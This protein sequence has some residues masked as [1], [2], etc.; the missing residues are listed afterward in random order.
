MTH[1]GAVMLL[2]LELGSGEPP[3]AGVVCFH[4]R[5]WYPGVAALLSSPAAA[6]VA[7]V[8]I[9]TD[10]DDPDLTR[11]EQLGLRAPGDPDPGDPL[12][13]A[14]CRWAL[15]APV[16]NGALDGFP[17]DRRP[18]RVPEKPLGQWLRLGLSRREAEAAHLAA[19]GLRNI[20]IAQH[21][22]VSEVT[23]KGHL[24]NAFRKLG[25]KR[26]PGLI[27][28]LKETVL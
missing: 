3:A 20:E 17:T 22:F 9:S 1:G 11:G 18:D 10:P 7:L 16:G 27:A 8:V 4:G 13:D 2:R 6:T 25:V 19:Q 15:C 14:W 23:V 12:T 21:L 5:G 28:F 26:R 24:R